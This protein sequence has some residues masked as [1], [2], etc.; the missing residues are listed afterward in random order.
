MTSL[1]GLFS[2]LMLLPGAMLSERTGKRKLLFV[3]CGAGAS[4]FSILRFAWLPFVLA[5]PTAIYFIIFIKVMADGLGNFS[6]PAWT[7][8]AGDIVSLAWRGRFIGIAYFVRFVKSKTG[9]GLV[10]D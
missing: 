7:S 10:G 5:R 4:R 3:L 1:A 9:D 8:M 6:G 2:T